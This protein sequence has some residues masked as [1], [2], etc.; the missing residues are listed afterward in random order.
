M[1]GIRRNL[2]ESAEVPWA[3]AMRTLASEMRARSASTHAARSGGVFASH[4]WPLPSS[5]Q[6]GSTAPLCTMTRRL[7]TCPLLLTLERTTRGGER[8]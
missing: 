6:R 4:D 8:R 2:K 5:P 1:E 3:L 7:A